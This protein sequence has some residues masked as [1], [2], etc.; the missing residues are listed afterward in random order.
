MEGSV[1]TALAAKGVSVEVR[2]SQDA[3]AD[4]TNVDVDEVYV[5]FSKAF[6]DALPASDSE[7][8]ISFDA[9]D[10]NHKTNEGNLHIANTDAAVVN[11]DPVATGDAP[12]DLMAVSVSKAT[13]SGYLVVADAQSYGI[14]YR[15]IG[16]SEWAK[17][18]PASSNAA[19][20]HRKARAVKGLTRADRVEYSVTLTG[21][22]AG[23]TYEYKAFCDGFENGAVN[24]FTTESPYELPYASFEEWSTY[25]ASTIL[26]PKTVDAPWPVGDKSASFWGSGNE[27]G[28]TAGKKLT[29]QS[30]DM[31]HSGTY[32]APRK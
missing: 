7:Y 9:T 32:S 1:Q 13:V 17:A 10:G 16:S 29:T 28:A 22:Q 8:C 19:A 11:P 26:G 27:G 4:G 18:Y 23:T 24:T 3:A 14:M 31:A 25:K 2:K 12:T 15:A 5:T 21:L 6:L 30:S 20:A